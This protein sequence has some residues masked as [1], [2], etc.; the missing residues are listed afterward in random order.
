MNR[1]KENDDGSNI[2]GTRGIEREK[3]GREEKGKK[4]RKKK[5]SKGNKMYRKREKCNERSGK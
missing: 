1:G 2:K 3:K 4:G 5:R